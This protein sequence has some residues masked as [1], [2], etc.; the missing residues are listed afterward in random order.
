[1]PTTLHRWLVFNLVGAL[2]F[3]VQL[4][5]LVLLMGRLRWGFAPATVLAVEA[6]VVHNF[7]YQVGHEF[8][9]LAVALRRALAQTPA[10]DLIQFGRDDGP[11]AHEF[12][13]F[14]FQDARDRGDGIRGCKRM[15]AGGQLIQHDAEGEYVGTEVDLQAKQLFGRRVG[16]LFQE[17]IRILVAGEERFDF[18]AER[19]VAR[20]G[21]VQKY[22][23]LR[24]VPFQCLVEHVL[25]LLPAIRLHVG[26][27][28]AS[29]A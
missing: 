26:F 5:V 3:V 8:T 2:G 28:L 20:T 9:G 4:G 18:F 25:E 14:R 11:E 10:H 16:R 7:F 17:T 23:T 13:R 21:F 12:H 29:H 19:G 24:R 1:M 27:P 22:G 15:R 6:A